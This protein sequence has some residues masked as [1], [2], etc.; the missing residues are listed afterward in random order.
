M[1]SN[2]RLAAVEA[3]IAAVCERAG[4]RRDSVRLLAV[5]KFHP[6][7]AV[8]ELARAGQQDFGESYVQEAQAKRNEL[9]A[10]WPDLR[11]HMIGHVQSR[12]AAAVAGAYHLIHSLDSVRLADALEKHLANSRQGVLIEVNIAE[13]PQKTGVTPDMLPGLGRHVSQAC[14]H[15]KLAGLM[16]LPPV[17]DDGEAARPYFAR[18]RRLRDGLEQ[19]LGQELPELSMGMSGDYETAIEEGATIVRVGTALFGPRPVKQ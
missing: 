7:Q 1:E 8:A 6:G 10:A 19:T 5:S 13:E 4:R 15:L 11:W 18:L 16:C 9:A 3:K 12:K 2:G 14:P 17:F